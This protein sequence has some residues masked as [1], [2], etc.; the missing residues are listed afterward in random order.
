MTAASDLARFRAW[1]T[2]R[3]MRRGAASDVA[4][5]LDHNRNWARRIAEGDFD[6]PLTEALRLAEALGS[7][8]GAIFKADAPAWHEW[9][10]VPTP[11][12][13]ALR[14]PDVIGAVEAL[15]KVP[16]DY[17]QHTTDSLRRL[18]KLPPIQRSAESTSET[19]QVTRTTQGRGRHREP[20]GNKAR[21]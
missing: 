11:L 13:V 15:L 5:A 17:R 3:L 19:T 14:D 20:R 8:L 2:T 1:L 16:A 7:S 6:P 10:I 18:A 12:A 21:E 9:I 4:R